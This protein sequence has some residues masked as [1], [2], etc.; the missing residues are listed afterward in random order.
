MYF[1]TL[2]RGSGKTGGARVGGGARPFSTKSRSPHA[3]GKVRA[4]HPAGN[5]P[6]CDLTPRRAT[7]KRA[8]F[9]GCANERVMFVCGTWLILFVPTR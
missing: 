9:G 1:A 2:N 4:V 7:V 8:L 3:L 6:Q 5:D